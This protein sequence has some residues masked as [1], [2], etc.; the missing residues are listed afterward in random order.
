MCLYDYALESTGL[1]TYHN[2]LCR[3]KNTVE[4]EQE[5]E[6]SDDNE[7]DWTYPEGMSRHKAAS[8]RI[9]KEKTVTSSPHRTGRG[10]GR[11]PKHPKERGH[12][13]HHHHGDNSTLSDFHSLKVSTE[14][15]VQDG[16]RVDNRGWTTGGGQ[17]GG[18]RGWGTG[19]VQGGQRGGHRVGNRVSNRVNT[20]WATGWN[21][22]WAQG[23]YRVQD[24]CCTIK[25]L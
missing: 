15:W 14:W 19:W 13:H 5:Q 21:T 11:P 7:E 10:P 3:L 22:G 4:S 18:H 1:S 20:G 6:A 9:K 16:Y 25:G 8:K 23:G 12:H 2:F 24:V 17:R